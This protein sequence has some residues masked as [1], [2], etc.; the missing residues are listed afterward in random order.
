MNP[1]RNATIALACT[2]MLASPSFGDEVT[3]KTGLIKG[4]QMTYEIN[5]NWTIEQ[6]DTPQG[7]PRTFKS[8]VGAM[9]VLKV[10]DVDDQG[11][12]R[13]SARFTSFSTRYEDQ[14]GPTSVAFDMKPDANPVGLATLEKPLGETTFMFSV[15]A[16]GKASD[17]SGGDDFFAALGQ[18][19]QATVEL[20]GFF[21]PNMMGDVFTQVFSCDGG[22]GAHET[23]D[24]WQDSRRIQMGS[25]GA[26]EVTTNSTLG[27]AQG[28]FA[29]ISGTTSFDLYVP[30]ER[31]ENAPVISLGESGGEV[32]TRWD[33]N[34]GG[35]IGRSANHELVIDGAV[36]DNRTVQ[37]QRAETRIE[38]K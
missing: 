34:K 23:G 12:A 30:R 25:A 7:D 9:V 17:F 21:R 38:R 11:N 14:T 35:L 26:I 27:I 19:E 29:A 3:L 20:F 24:T 36:G 10:V 15:N 32:L 22:I 4:R 28:D 31:G 5:Q 37:W 8:D 13:V 16:E 6:R 1:I 18:N 2:A 33:T